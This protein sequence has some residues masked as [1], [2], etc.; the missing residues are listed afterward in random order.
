MKK[1]LVT[2]GSGF[3]GSH[4]VVALVE[5]GYE[6]IILDT[7]ENSD[8]LILEG[9]SKI[10]GFAPKFYQID[11]RDKTALWSVFQQ[12]Q[13]EAV[14]HFAAYKAVGESVSEP[15]KYYSNNIVSLI[16]LLEVMDRFEC[17]KLVFSSSCT[18]YGQPDTLPVRETSDAHNAASPYGYTK[19]VC[20]QL[21]RDLAKAGCPLQ[22]AILRYF[23]PVGAHPSAHIGELPIG[24]PNNLIPYITQTAAGIRPKLIVH[25]SDYDTPDGSGVRD[26]IHVVDL[27]EAHVAALRW[28]ESTA[29]SADDF[30]LGQ[31]KGDSV[32]EVVNAFIRVTGVSLPFEIGPRRQGDIEQIF[33]DVSKAKRELGWQTKLT[34]E[35]ALKDAWRWQLRLAERS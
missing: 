16:H 22:S 27:A 30:N 29:L 14:I 31:G 19:V 18:V 8:P 26:F 1:V 17:R 24:V 23:N 10:I 13:P 32:L 5:S 20:E 6:P 7:L 3:I 11:C 9:I 25:G 12:E 28:L 21:I 2:G 35:D 4:T 15:L 34:I 33:A